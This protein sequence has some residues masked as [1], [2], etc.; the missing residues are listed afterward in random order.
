MIFQSLVM[1]LPRAVFSTSKGHSG[2]PG[3]KLKSEAAF[4]S[5]EHAEQV[6]QISWRYLV[7][8]AKKLNSISRERLT[9]GRRP[10]LCTTLCRKFRNPIQL[11]KRAISVAHLTNF[12]FEFFYEIFTQDAPSS[13]SILYSAKKSKMTKKLKS[14]G[15]LPLI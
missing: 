7:Q 8:A 2:V 12:S 5:Q 15:S 4:G 1:I 6:C 10:I 13:L 3:Q 9:F 14:R 11:N